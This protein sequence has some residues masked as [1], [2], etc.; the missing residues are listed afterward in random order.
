VTSLHEKVENIL[1]ELRE[2]RQD[3]RQKRDLDNHRWQSL[4]PAIQSL[5]SVAVRHPSGPVPIVQMGPK[6]DLSTGKSV[7]RRP[8]NDINP[9]ESKRL[10]FAPYS[11]QFP[12]T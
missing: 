10:R 9:T 4:W 1:Q 5:S 6:G 2:L 8:S 11:V 12:K 7:K 3:F